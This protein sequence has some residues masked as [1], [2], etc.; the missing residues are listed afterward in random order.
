MVSHSASSPTSPLGNITQIS[1]AI[2]F[3]KEDKHW[4]KMFKFVYCK[5][6][7]CEKCHWSILVDEETHN[8]NNTIIL[9]EAHT[10][11]RKR[12]HMFPIRQSG[13]L[14]VETPSLHSFLSSHVMCERK[15]ACAHVCLC[16]CDGT[17]EGAGAEAVD[18]IHLLEISSAFRLF[19]LPPPV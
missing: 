13:L 6:T 15:K 4:W 1:A 12:K 10:H 9:S 8:D 11:T 5:I 17:E 18:Q 7:Y 14:R 16:M 2:V 19:C 3:G